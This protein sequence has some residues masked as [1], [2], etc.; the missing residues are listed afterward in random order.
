MNKADSWGKGVRQVFGRTYKLTNNFVH[1]VRSDTY[2][3]FHLMA[4]VWQR[5]R[6]ARFL[7]VLQ[8]KDQ[9]VVL[10]L[11][12]TVNFFLCH[13]WEVWWLRWTTAKTDTGVCQALLT[14]RG[15][16]SVVFYFSSPTSCSQSHVHLKFCLNPRLFDLQQAVISDN[17]DAFQRTT[18]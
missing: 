13:L 7:P 1:T 9:T 6:E 10:K 4:S 15:T 18:F 2:F 5:P 8:S 17:S 12:L 14:C 3:V 16:P 11:K